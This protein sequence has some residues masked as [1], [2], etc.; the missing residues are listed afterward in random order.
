MEW[1]RR[2][3]EDMQDSLVVEEG[4]IFK[5]LLVPLVTCL[6]P[7]QLLQHHRHLIEKNSNLL[8]WGKSADCH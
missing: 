7:L 8:I 2:D 1:K 4:M 6:L 3:G 5:F